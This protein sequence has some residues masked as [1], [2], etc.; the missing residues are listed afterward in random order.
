MKISE[1]AAAL[2]R[3]QFLR[4]GLFGSMALST[5]SA[6]ALLTGCSRLTAAQ[7]FQVLRDSDLKVLRAVVPVVLAGELP[8]DR[9]ASAAVEETLHTFDA[10]LRGT[11]LTAQ[12]QFGQLLDLLHMPVTRYTIAGLSS[13]W[14]EAAPAEIATF[15]EH[16]RRSRFDTLRA[17]YS[18]LTQA[19]NMMW[20]LQP[21]SWA[22]I[23]YLPPRV[24]A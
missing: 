18:G 13:D 12:K 21:R 19:V 24:V 23:N 22:A 7:G 15:L 8:Q 4:I 6:T 10:F 11:S 2:S 5:I 1:P 17:G 20:Y 9:T 16:W 3:R 14:G